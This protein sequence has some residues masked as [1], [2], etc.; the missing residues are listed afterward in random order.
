MRYISFFQCHCKC[1]IAHNLFFFFFSLDLTGSFFLSSEFSFAAPGFQHVYLWALGWRGRRG[2][3]P[4]CLWCLKEA[5]GFVPQCLG[6][7]G[8]WWEWTIAGKTQLFC[9]YF[10]FTV[11]FCMQFLYSLGFF[12]FLVVLLWFILLETALKAEDAGCFPAGPIFSQP[13]RHQIFLF[14]NSSPLVKKEAYLVFWLRWLCTHLLAG[15]FLSPKKS[16]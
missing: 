8:E 11:G 2:A 7:W 4:T 14:I 6:L 16:M 15:I 3:L 5:L 13:P 10:C 1:V 9:F 12:F